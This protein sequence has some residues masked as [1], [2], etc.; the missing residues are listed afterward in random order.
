[1]LVPV[2]LISNSPGT[3]NVHE[4]VFPSATENYGITQDGDESKISLVKLFPK[5]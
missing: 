3:C 4:S 1:M 2:G 5:Y